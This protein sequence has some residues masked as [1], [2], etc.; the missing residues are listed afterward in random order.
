[1]PM[2]IVLPIVVTLFA[3]LGSLPALG[4]EPTTVA[5]TATLRPDEPQAKKQ[6]TESLLALVELAVQ[7]DTGLA[8]VERRQIDLVLQEQVLNQA[9]PSEATLQLGKLVTADLLVMLERAEPERDRKNPFVRLRIVDPQTASIRG[10]NV[11]ELDEETLEE[12]AEQF[13]QYAS[14]V[15][16]ARSDP[17]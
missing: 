15:V 13:A 5:L 8:I 7:A 2:R 14:S 3:L 6:L 9:R 10:V 12:T 16:R 11:A 4:A 17:R 1:M